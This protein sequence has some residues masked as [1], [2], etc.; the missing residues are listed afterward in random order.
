[1]KFIH[2]LSSKSIQA[3]CG[4]SSI[5]HPPAASVIFDNYYAMKVVREQVANSNRHFA[6]IYMDQID[7]NLEEIEKHSPQECIDSLQHKL[8][9]ENNL[10]E[11]MQ[12]LEVQ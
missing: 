3:D 2:R 6:A 10:R 9:F 11:Q 4:L 8:D 7:R 5:C 1:M 12:A